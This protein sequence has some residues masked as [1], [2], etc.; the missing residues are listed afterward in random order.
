M[1]RSLLFLAYFFPPRGGAGVQ[2]SVKF[3]KYLPQF[4]WNPLVVA[5]GGTTR[6]WVSPVEDQ[7]LLKDVPAGTVVRYTRLNDRELRAYNSA[8]KKWRHR[9]SIT[10]PIGWW[11]KPATRLGLEMIR[12]HKPETIFVTMSPFTAARAGIELKRQT[13]L[14]L[15]LDLRDPWSLDET[16]MYPTR[17]HASRDWAAMA[18]AFSAADLIIMNTPQSAVAAAEEF[19]S[20][21]QGLDPAGG[22]CKVIWITNG[23]D[24]E[25][26]GKGGDSHGGA[27]IAGASAGGKSGGLLGGASGAVEPVGK[28]VLRIVHTGSFHSE[29]AG[30]WDDLFAGRGWVNKFKYPRRP[31]N[32]WTR[33]PRYLLE[34]MERLIQR[35]DIP[36]G[37]IELVLVGEVS[38]GDRALVESSPAAKMVKLLGYRSH[39]ES[40]RW[41]ESAD[42]LFLPNHTPLDGGPALIVPGKTYEYLGSGRPILAMGPSGDMMDFVRSTKSGVCLKGDDVEGAAGALKEFYA[43]KIKGQA[44]I[45]QDRAAV[46]AFERRELTKRLAGALDELVGRREA[47]A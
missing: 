37:K 22:K 40:V 4:G 20:Q 41:V 3:A 43:A 18:R 39:F 8:Q 31:I 47:V 27:P 30:L 42:V 33:T 1:S 28:D 32:L 13:G 46:R 7:S 45:E 44:A 23:Y 25:D 16:R 38:P 11:A 5:N 36:Q 6:D 26:F 2:R 12:E 34:A 15:V 9:L 10:D 17:W 14:P 35:G 19:G 29:M 24:A 21:V